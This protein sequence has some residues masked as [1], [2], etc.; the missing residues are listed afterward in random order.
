[1]DSYGSLNMKSNN[2]INIAN[3]TFMKEKS[4]VKNNRAAK[5][6]IEERDGSFISPY[7]RDRKNQKNQNII[8]YS[9]E[10]LENQKN[11]NNTINNNN[12]INKVQTLY[13]NNKNITEPLNKNNSKILK[14]SKLKKMDYNLK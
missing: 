10:S 12:I 1:M 14:N 3:K 13:N 7:N 4:N 9:P 11:H 6:A 5:S 8:M 2:L